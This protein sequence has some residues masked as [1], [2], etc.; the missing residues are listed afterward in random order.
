MNPIQRVNLK[1]YWK[2]K[3]DVR[4]CI[5][6]V[7]RTKELGTDAGSKNAKLGYLQLLD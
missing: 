4:Y 6:I 1:S 7:A 5:V 2:E 3:E